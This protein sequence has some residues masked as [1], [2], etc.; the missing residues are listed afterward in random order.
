MDELVIPVFS[1]VLS[2][3]ASLDWTGPLVV[4]AIP[5]GIMGI[6]VLYLRLSRRCRSWH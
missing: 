2:V 3:T 4:I 5:I 6:V 1:R